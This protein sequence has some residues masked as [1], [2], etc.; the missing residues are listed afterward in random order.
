MRGKPRRATTPPRPHPA[1]PTE[2]AS[3]DD[4]EADNPNARLVGQL[5][6]DKPETYYALILL[7]G[8]SMGAWIPAP[9][10]TSC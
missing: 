4:P 1:G 7:D 5:L 8:D 3:S 6:G 10:R 9:T 2:A